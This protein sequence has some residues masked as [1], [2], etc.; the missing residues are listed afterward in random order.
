M[1]GTILQRSRSTAASGHAVGGLT[2]ILKES[3][4]ISGYVAPA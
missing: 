3:L 1:I 2:T 4:Q